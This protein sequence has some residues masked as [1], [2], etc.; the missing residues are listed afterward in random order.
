[1]RKSSRPCVPP[2]RPARALSRLDVKR[3]RVLDAKRQHARLLKPASLHWKPGFASKGTSEHTA[4]A[5]S[6]THLPYGLVAITAV[7]C[8]PAIA[9]ASISISAPGMPRFPLTVERAG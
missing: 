7:S 1:M 5:L 8:A 2:S 4:H 9:I 6:P 3:K